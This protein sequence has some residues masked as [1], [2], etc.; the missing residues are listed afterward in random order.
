MV[1][2]VVIHI[3]SDVLCKHMAGFPCPNTHTHTRTH[4]DTLERENQQ[5]GRERRQNT[6][7]DFTTV[8]EPAAAVLSG[9]DKGERLAVNNN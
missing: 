6:H 7:Q 8:A 1:Y 2:E 5:S 4:K 3:P 9:Q